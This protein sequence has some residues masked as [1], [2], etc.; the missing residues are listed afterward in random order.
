MSLAPFLQATAATSTVT[1]S[2]EAGYA[3]TA[4]ANSVKAVRG[5]FHVPAV[6][7]PSGEQVDFIIGMDN[8]PSWFT[9]AKANEVGVD[10][11][12][13]GNTAN[14]FAFYVTPGS[15]LNFAGNVKAGDLIKGSVAYV[16]GV[17]SLSLKDIT[18]GLSISKTSS[19]VGIS[20]S[21]AGWLVAT[22]GV[23]LPNFGTFGA[24]VGH[25]GV[26][27]TDT[28]T[29]GT[30]TGSIGSFAPIAGDTVVRIQMSDPSGGAATTSS[31]TNGGT[32]FTDVWS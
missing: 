9:F 30:H 15:N 21:V 29:I 27:K 12:C 22:G 17:V 11:R 32:S 7:C 26:S 2:T 24:G 23:A 5:S 14:Y 25:T 4:P 6:T 10:A 18:S 20:R 28:A 3:V 1:T 31:L 19:G 16:N 13:N 8:Y